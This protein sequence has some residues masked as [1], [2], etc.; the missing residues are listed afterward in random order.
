MSITIS[1]SNCVENNTNSS[2]KS[3]SSKKQEKAQESQGLMKGRSEVQLLPIKL[4][5]KNLIQVN[6]S[7]VGQTGIVI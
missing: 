7:I 3:G 6:S 4:I 1:K 2:S 5:P